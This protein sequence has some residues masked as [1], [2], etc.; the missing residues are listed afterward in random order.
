MINGISMMTKGATPASLALVAS[1]KK[2][3]AAHT[4]LASSKN[5]SAQWI[6]VKRTLRTV[7]WDW[8]QLAGSELSSMKGNHWWVLSRRVSWYYSSLQRSLFLMK[9]D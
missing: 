5:G 8:R 2:E 7:V 6:G 1:Q 3:W 4:H 9:N